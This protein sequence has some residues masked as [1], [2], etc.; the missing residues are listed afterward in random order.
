MNITHMEIWR[1]GYIKLNVDNACLVYLFV[2][3]PK[4]MVIFGLIS[5]LILGLRPANERRRYFVMAQ[6]SNPV[7]Q[8][9]YTYY[10]SPWTPKI[11][12]TRMDISLP[13]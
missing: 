11:Y 12:D 5:G 7:I 10:A 2:K 4:Y 6:I 1:F 9:T 3:M 13:H 8:I